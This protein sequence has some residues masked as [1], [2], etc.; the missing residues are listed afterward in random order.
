[1]KPM[2]VLAVAVLTTI[3][4]PHSAVAQGETCGANAVEIG[5]SETAGQVTLNCRCNAGFTKSGG[6]CVAAQPVIKS[7]PVRVAAMTVTG[8][9]TLVSADG[10]RTTATSSKRLTLPPGTRIVT[11]PGSNV[12]LEFSNASRVRVGADSVFAVEVPPGPVPFSMRLARGFMELVETAHNRGRIRTPTVVVAV[13]GTRVRISVTEQGSQVTLDAG[14]VEVLDSR[15]KLL[16]ILA[17]HQAVNISTD[18]QAS[19]PHA[20]Q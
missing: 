16:V 20:A 13:R 18:G 6:E 10:S 1:M 14:I 12:L 8:S 7:M 2:Y 15:G 17:P 19:S 3:P 9:V 4:A 5:R 11:G